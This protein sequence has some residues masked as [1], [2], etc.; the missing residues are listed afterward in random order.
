MNVP[1]IVVKSSIGFAAG[2]SMV[3]LGTITWS[4]L[5]VVTQVD[6][7]TDSMVEIKSNQVKLEYEV[8]SYNKDSRIHQE[9]MAKKLTDIEVDVSAIKINVGA[10]RKLVTEYGEMTKELCEAADYYWTERGCKRR[11][12]K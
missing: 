1:D 10:N 3:L 4:A 2:L 9:I 12:R 11:N 7:A 6:I 5:R 8:K